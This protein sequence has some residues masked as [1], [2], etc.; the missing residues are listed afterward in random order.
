MRASRTSSRNSRWTATVVPTADSVRLRSVFRA[1]NV[2]ACRHADRR[3]ADRRTGCSESRWP[4]CQRRY[5]LACEPAESAIVPP[6]GGV[7]TDMKRAACQ[8][9][10]AVWRREALPAIGHSILSRGD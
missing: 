4:R 8:S 10:P 6:T 3:A 5:E 2:H 9:D 7:D 1:D